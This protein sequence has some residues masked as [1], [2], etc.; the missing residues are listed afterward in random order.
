MKVIYFFLISF[1]I[2][3]CQTPNA[4]DIINR[5]ISVS[6]GNKYETANIQFKFREKSYQITG[7]N[8]ERLMIR[9]SKSDGDTI[10]DILSKQQFQRYLND[11]VVFVEDSMQY[12]FSESINSVFYF[13]LLP[14]KLND[15]AVNKRLL[16]KTEIDNQTYYEI[17]VTFNKEGG[18]ADFEDVYIYWINENSFKIEYLAYSFTVNGG[19]MRFRK[20]YNERFVN[21]IRFVD[22]INYK[23]KNKVE[24]VKDLDG[25]FKENKLIELSKIE[26]TEITVSSL[27][28]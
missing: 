13:A 9:Q 21:G 18:G 22:Y 24:K 6:G 16:G 11:S 1:S 12:K 5:S 23:P 4:E 7:P 10:T 14:F 8:S 19:G 26:L 20:A 2:Y 17:E 3:S 27:N 28:S 15:T 25:L